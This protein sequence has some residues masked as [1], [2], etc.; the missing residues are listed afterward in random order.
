MVN[1]KMTMGV[2]VGNRGFFPDHLAKDRPEE[3]LQVLEAAGNERRCA[4]SGSRASTEPLRPTRKRSGVPTCSSRTG[5]DRRH[6][7]HLA[8]LWR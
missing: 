2:I 5:I 3:M 7:R 4:Q 6:H 8:E 1:K